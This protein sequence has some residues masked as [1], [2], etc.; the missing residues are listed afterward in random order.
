MKILIVDDDRQILDALSLGI[1]TLWS[2]VDICTASDGNTALEMLGSASPEFVLLDLG[3]PG[4]SGLDVLREIRKR[5]AVPVI[6]VTARG[7]E[8]DQVL[9]LDLGADDYLVKPVGIAALK[10][11]MQAVMRRY[12]QT[13]PVGGGAAVVA[14]GVAIDLENGSATLSGRPLRLTP[15]EYRLLSTLVRSRGEVVTH[16]ALIGKLWGEEYG[17]TTSHLKVFVS[18]LR[19]KIERPGAPQRIETERGVGY[20]FVVDD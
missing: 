10:A 5:S 17:A 3:L 4:K 1:Q 8:S 16:E 11:R 19:S 12:E 15:L 7:E 20:R 14:G 2:E 6:I 13:Q 18:R 9:G